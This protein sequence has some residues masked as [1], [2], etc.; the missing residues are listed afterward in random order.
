MA[1]EIGL[2]EVMHGFF[3]A[4]PAEK[5]R[6]GRL[7]L[8][9]SSIA[10][11]PS[12]TEA[13]ASTAWCGSPSQFSLLLPRHEWAQL[14]Y[15]RESLKTRVELPGCIRLRTT[16]QSLLEDSSCVLKALRSQRD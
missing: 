12:P 5:G 1:E 16:S 2:A 9:S 11:A 4:D 7:E 14:P 10:P 3:L 6:E 15:Q 8:L 13:E